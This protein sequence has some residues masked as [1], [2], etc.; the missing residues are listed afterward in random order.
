MTYQPVLVHYRN[1]V[2][3]K[4]LKKGH[5]QNWKFCVTE[6]QEVIPH[7]SYY[8]AVLL[9]ELFRI[10]CWSSSVCPNFSKKRHHRP[11]YT[12]ADKLLQC[13]ECGQWINEELISL[14]QTVS[15]EA[16]EIIK[17]CFTRETVVN[18]DS[19][20]LVRAER[21][22]SP[23]KVWPR[24]LCEDTTGKHG[25]HKWKPTSCQVSADNWRRPDMEAGSGPRRGGLLGASCCLSHGG[26]HHRRVR[27]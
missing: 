27:R 11:L 1:G 7:G 17:V 4:D 6:R 24:S 15:V 3:F 20:H 22:N 16:R 5:F 2:N 18:C 21:I 12:L 26:H 23:E 10:Y 13:Y 14:W 19:R 8:D 25:A 9:R